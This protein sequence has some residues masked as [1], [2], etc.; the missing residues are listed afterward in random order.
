MRGALRHNN[1][2]TAAAEMALVLPILL[3]LL[4]GALELGNY[5]MSEHILLKGVRDGAIYAA[6]QDILTNYNCSAGTPTV[7]SGVVT[8]TK[9]LVRTGQL[10]GGADKLPNWESGSTVFTITA[11]CQTAAGGTTLGGMYVTNGGN[12][13]V[14]TVNATLPYRSIF[15]VLGFNTVNLNLGASEQ[16]VAIGL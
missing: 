1:R 15:G 6:R 12:V 9:T 10:S 2:G 13:P 11:T 7:P 4:F 16:A 3:I 8:S 14:L 5:F